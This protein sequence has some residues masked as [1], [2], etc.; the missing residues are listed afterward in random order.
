MRIINRSIFGVFLVAA[1]SLNFAAATVHAEPA[2]GSVDAQTANPNAP[3]PADKPNAALTSAAR[4]QIK[5][6]LDEKEK[7][8][9]A[10]KAAGAAAKPPA[11]QNQQ[12][13]AATP[14]QAQAT[15]Q[16]KPAAKPDTP[17][18]MVKAGPEQGE[19]TGDTVVPVLPARP[20]VNDLA[21]W[22]EEQ[23]K[24]SEE[25]E[26][27]TGKYKGAISEQ[28]MVF[29]PQDKVTYI[30]FSRHYVNHIRCEGTIQAL[31]MPQDRG[32]EFNLLRNKHD[33]YLRVGDTPYIQFPLDL[34]IKCDDRS[35]T[36]NGLVTPRVVSQEIELQVPKKG[37]LSAAEKEKFS[38]A[39]VK[40][41][42]MPLEEQ[43][44]KI[45]QRI[46]KGDTLTYWKDLD[47][48]AAKSR[49]TYKNYSVL[50]QKAVDTN[51]NGLLA[52]DFVFRGDFQRQAAYDDIRKVVRGEV[53]AYGTYEYAGKGMTRMIVI[54]KKGVNDKI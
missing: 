30:E 26:K 9:A 16:K 18:G 17:T 23:N 51:I 49:W 41:S 37:E 8:A 27:V 11:G 22:T 7:Q 32:M 12:A 54:T 36:I 15:T 13:P 43:V 25:Y 21:P 40:S 28:K 29:V 3:K 6:L 34:S 33:L 10:A 19:K 1:I 52:W 45:T 53:V 39:I 48:S 38:E 31:I 2:T 5:K 20:N 35:Y 46:F 14:A 50:L 47:I 42:A 24:N 44:A 4:D